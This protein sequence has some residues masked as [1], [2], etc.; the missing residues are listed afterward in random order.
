MIRR[1]ARAIL[2]LYTL[3]RLGTAAA[4]AES[5]DKPLQKKVV[6][7]GRSEYL[8]SNDNRHVTLTCSYYSTFMIK[9]LNDP[10][11]KGA[12]SISVS[13]DHA[14]C[15]KTSGPG[16]RLFNDQD[17]HPWDGY[18]AGVKQNLVFLRRSDGDGGGLPFAAFDP[19]TG[20]KLFEDSVRLGSGGNLDLNFVH[21]SSSQI[22]LRY[23]RVVTED[24]SIP[25]DGSACWN[26]FKDKSGLKL[27]PMPSCNY[28]G[29]DPRAPSVI[30]YRVEVSLFPKPSIKALANPVDCW[31]HE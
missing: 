16:E 6:D 1:N 31:P 13:P 18:F 24:C 11:N 9:E 20:T 26:K 30:D 14:A 3:G 25:K 22:T 29:E 7:I 10:G 5:F 12:L 15:T 19:T 8:M 21:A 23:S 28:R 4:H 17:G 27:A 2:L